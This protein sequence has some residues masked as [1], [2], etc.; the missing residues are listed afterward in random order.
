LFGAQEKNEPAPFDAP[1]IA[2]PGSGPVTTRSAPMRED[3]TRA[4][5]NA[6]GLILRKKK[7]RL[8]IMASAGTFALLLVLLVLDLSGV[9]T[10]PAFGLAY[11]L[12]GISNPHQADPGAPQFSD[13]LTEEE[14]RRIREGLMGKKKPDSPT[15]PEAKARNEAEGDD[16]QLDVKIEAPKLLVAEADLPKGLTVATITKTVTA[17]Q[18]DV[19]ACYEKSLKRGI[20]VGGRLEVEFSIINSGDVKATEVKSAKHKGTDMADCVS[21]AIKGWKFPRFAGDPVTVEYPFILSTGN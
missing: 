7:Q 20:Q 12:V 8:Y 16:T 2:E 3:S 14:R 17:N 21:T 19:K 13:N 1:P 5:I 10:I 18:G 15:P 6:S 4:V 11:N 9:I